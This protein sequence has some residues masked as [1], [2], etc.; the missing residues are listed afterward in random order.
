[1]GLFSGK[2]VEGQ[3]GLDYSIKDP[4]GVTRNY[5]VTN[6][7]TWA[8][9][10]SGRRGELFN[11]GGGERPYASYPVNN[12]G[13]G[14]YV[15]FPKNNFTGIVHMWGAGGGAY[16]DSGGRFA[17]GGGYA[18]AIINFV[19][20][21]PYTFIVGEG[22]HWNSGATHGGGGRGHSSGGSGG[23]LSGIFFNTD[24]IGTDV[25][26]GSAAPV[27]QANAL[28][29]AGGGGGGGHHTQNS[30]YGQAGGGGGWVGKRAHAGDGGTQTRG[31]NAG[32]SNSQA[33]FALHGGHS[34][35]NT[36]WLGGGGGGWFG[37][38]GGGHSG[39]HH[40]GGNGGSGHIAYDSNIATQPNNALSRYI[41]QGFM[42]KAPGHFNYTD[43]R[44]ANFTNPLNLSEGRHAGQGGHGEG[45]GHHGGPKSTYNARNGKIVL[46]LLPDFF[47]KLQFPTHNQPHESNSWSQAY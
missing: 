23:G 11:V 41:V 45:S 26:N 16:H 37:G 30:H 1:M 35:S 42:E 22:G 34:G 36:S 8:D 7:T 13:Y 43:N 15:F 2:A 10:H 17:G 29:I 44:P 4:A 39:S 19:A 12:F 32:Y 3:Y 5:T 31:G 18:Q 9:G 24:Y 38:G 25:W 20:D 14:S 21:V 46:T 47:G 6:E 27:S 40:D 28:I 33:G